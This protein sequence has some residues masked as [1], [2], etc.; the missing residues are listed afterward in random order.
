MHQHMPWL[1]LTTML[2]FPLVVGLGG[3]LT[4]GGSPLLLAAIAA[5]P[6]LTVLVIVAAMGHEILRSSSSGESDVPNLP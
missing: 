3:F 4:A 5:L 1:V 6:G 2:A